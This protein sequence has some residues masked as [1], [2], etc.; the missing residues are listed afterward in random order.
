MQRDIDST[1]NRA[2]AVNIRLFIVGILHMT[3]FFGFVLSTV[4]VIVIVFDKIRDSV[5]DLVLRTICLH[6]SVLRNC[7]YELIH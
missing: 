3:P 1:L 6:T 2:V 5:R 7:L 4:S